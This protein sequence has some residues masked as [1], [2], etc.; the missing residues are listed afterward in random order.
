MPCKQRHN[1][2]SDMLMLFASFCCAAVAF[3]RLLQ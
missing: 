3:V 1:C 2:I